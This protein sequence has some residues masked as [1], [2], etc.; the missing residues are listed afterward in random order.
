LNEFEQLLG[1]FFRLKRELAIA[2]GA[3]APDRATVDR[4]RAEM[5][6]TERDIGALE[7][8]RERAAHTLGD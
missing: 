4:L 3:R 6:Q 8:V 1:R 7:P 2:S 5:A